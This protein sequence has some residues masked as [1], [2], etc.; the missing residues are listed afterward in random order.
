MAGIFE[1][2]RNA[3]TLCESSKYWV[4]VYCFAYCATDQSWHSS[5]RYENQR[6]RYTRSERYVLDLMNYM[7]ARYWLEI[8]L[9]TQAISNV[10]KSSFGPSGLDKMMVDDIGV[11]L[12]RCVSWKYTFWLSARMLRSQMMA[13]QSWVSWISNTLPVK[14]WLIWPNNRIRR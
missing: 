4:I 11:S 5:R 3:G 8:V 14:Y 10:V 7:M 6:R 2:P 1:Q 12:N 9:A 13:P